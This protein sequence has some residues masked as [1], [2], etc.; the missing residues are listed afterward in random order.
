MSAQHVEV[1][2]ALLVLAFGLLIFLAGLIPQS[3][4]RSGYT[5]SGWK[6]AVLV[7]GGCVFVIGA[8]YGMRQAL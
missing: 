6:R 4:F 7:A 8:L 1:L 5:Q 3:R 2:K